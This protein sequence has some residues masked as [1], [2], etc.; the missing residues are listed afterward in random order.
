MERFTIGKIGMKMKNRNQIINLESKHYL[1]KNHKHLK[2]EIPMKIND[3]YET[4]ID[5]RTNIYW[6]II[7]RH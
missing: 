3:I 4:L 6:N 1:I 5:T 7:N 2:T